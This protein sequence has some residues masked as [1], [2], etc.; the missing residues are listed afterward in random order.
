MDLVP[1]AS[2][3][4]CAVSSTT[5][6]F[7]PAIDPEGWVVSEAALVSMAGRPLTFPN[8]T[9]KTKNVAELATLSD[10]GVGK[11]GL[12]P[13]RGVYLLGLTARR[14][15]K[16]LKTV[17]LKVLAE[18]IRGLQRQRH[19]N[20]ATVIP[21][22]AE[23]T[24]LREVTTALDKHWASGDQPVAR[25][26]RD[27]WSP[28][29]S[30]FSK[31][32]ESHEIDEVADR[33]AVIG[34]STQPIPG[35]DYGT[36][37]SSDPEVHTIFVPPP[38]LTPKGVNPAPRPFVALFAH[39]AIRSSN[40]LLLKQHITVASDPEVETVLRHCRAYPFATGSLASAVDLAT[41]QLQIATGRNLAS[42]LDASIAS[43]E[44]TDAS[45]LTLNLQKGVLTQP[46]LKPPNAFTP[47]AGAT[48]A[49]EMP[50]SQ[51]QLDL[52]PKLIKVLRTVH[53]RHGTKARRLLDWFDGRSPDEAIRIA[54]RGVPGL[55]PIGRIPSRHRRW[56][57]SQL[58]EKGRDLVQTML[59]CG[60]THGRCVAPLYYHSPT[61]ESLTALY[62]KSVWPLFNDDPTGLPPQ[63]TGERVGPA[64]LPKIALSRAGVRRL[65]HRLNESADAVV[66]AG[67]LRIA[68]FHNRFVDYL[69]HHICIITSHRPSKALYALTRN[70]FDLE[71][72]ICVLSDK[73]VDLAHVTRLCSM[74]PRLSA[75]IRGYM[76][77]LEALAGL[78]FSP[79]EL[80]R[81]IKKIL[82][83]KAPLLA[84]LEADLT[85]RLG[86]EIEWK[87]SRPKEW[88]SLPD[89]WYR[90]FVAAKLREMGVPADAVF[91]QLGHL[92][93]AGQ[94]FG[95]DSP[96]S[97]IL[98]M[99]SLREG[100]GKIEDVLGVRVLKGL[101]SA[102]YQEALPPLQTWDHLI[103]QHEDQERAARRSELEKL[104]AT[105]KESRVR[106]VEWLHHHLPEV[107]PSAEGALMWISRHRRG[108][109]SETPFWRAKISP[110]EVRSL[111]NLAK[112]EFSE[113]PSVQV[114]I[115]NQLCRWLRG[116][117][118]RLQVD[119]QD[120]G[121]ITP[122]PIA[123]LSPFLKDNC[124]ATQQMA[125]ARKYLAEQAKRGVVIPNPA[126]AAL[127]LILYGYVT[128][129]DLVLQ[130]LS[131]PA[132]K[133]SVPP[134]DGDLLIW[135]HDQGE[136][137]GFCDLASIALSLLEEPVV[138]LCI[139]GLSRAIALHLPESLVGSAPEMT[140][141]RLCE[142]A[143]VAARIEYSSVARAAI[144]D[145]TDATPSHQAAFF[146]R[147]LPQSGR[148]VVGQGTDQIDLADGDSGAVDDPDP[149]ERAEVGCWKHW[150]PLR[151]TVSDPKGVIARQASPRSRTNSKGLTHSRL[152]IRRALDIAFPEPNDPKG[153]KLSIIQ[154]L[155][156]FARDMAING[157]TQKADPA[158]STI[159]TY[160]SVIGPSLVQCFAGVDLRDL[161]PDDFEDG[162][163]LVL[164]A[165]STARSRQRA[166]LQAKH[167]HAVIQRV[168]AIGSIEWAWLNEYDLESE[169]R[170]KPELIS[171]AEYQLA[172]DWLRQQLDASALHAADH[173]G[174]RRHCFAT[175]IILML[176][177]RTGARI[178]EIVR[179]RHDDLL[180]FGDHIALIIR[181]SRFR[182]LKTKAAR[183]LVDLTTRLTAD[184][185]TLLRQW[186]NVMEGCRAPNKGGMHPLFGT[187]DDGSQF[188]ATDTVRKTIQA[189]FQAGAGREMWPH[190]LRHAWVS[191]EYPKAAGVDLEALNI[192]GVR[193]FHNVMTE[194]G[195]ARAKTG[196]GSYLHTGWRFRSQSIDALVEDESMRWILRWVSGLSVDHVDKIWHRAKSNISDGPRP[197][198]WI[199]AVAIK[200]APV[201]I[202]VREKAVTDSSLSVVPRGGHLT[203]VQLD[204]LLELA[205]DE[206]E[207]RRLAPGFGISAARVEYLIGACQWLAQDAS[208]RLLSSK[209]RRN[210]SGREPLPRLIG[211]DFVGQ[212]SVKEW[213]RHAGEMSQLFVRCYSP[214]EARK[215]RLVGAAH[216][217]A[218]LHGLMIDVG[219]P[220]SLLNLEGAGPQGVLK[221]GQG[222]KISGFHRMTRLLALISIW[223]RIW[224]RI[225][226]KSATDSD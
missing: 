186:V 87:R 68:E 12:D 215:D 118:E 32:L 101:A 109:G 59:L 62:K 85:P 203:L 172:I 156:T 157:T 77:H 201:R 44:S 60:D 47:A 205:G 105:M 8:F 14:S 70:A 152:D 1:W 183:R 36:C 75:Q 197:D 5:P 115:H 182:A 208:Y 130:L 99:R 112:D 136:P 114:A 173:T 95:P 17:H 84:Y 104:R 211:F 127:A 163:R 168:H 30:N 165:A 22:I 188:V 111:N 98:L 15:S 27:G 43:E 147:Q 73:R 141:A 106:A 42:L 7:L 49:F 226:T 169:S 192:D 212:V 159:S 21:Q 221:V 204:R 64:H 185:R 6:W 28:W 26:W 131:K 170:V 117:V 2:K 175:L 128:D 116:A 80:V 74:T 181:P 58:Q 140:L 37:S 178:S 9:G 148:L 154:A 209:T 164:E 155:A 16:V 102:D 149:R 107:A 113:D 35:D 63:D 167:F 97:P 195:H 162:Y 139:E 194:A 137:Q 190:L 19:S 67:P 218:R 161:D 123:E 135:Q 126:R 150:G 71:R 122:R 193:S 4:L 153:C 143:Q 24:N 10:G 41:L 171:E 13:L 55:T 52:P 177:R 40:S 198:R 133:G 225:P 23:L 219:V 3:R 196:I 180:D 108:S 206:A 184:E 207:V 210:T 90:S 92:E 202:A 39:Q 176:L 216:D 145:S 33:P 54:L 144:A 151:R 81:H 31:Q 79:D 69:T 125:A 129:P 121:L 120:I 132:T 224:V 103:R 110:D 179:L 18:H 200:A 83:G 100:L 214:Y 66:E 223:P 174:W 51:L 11:V 158:G 142:T 86:T 160:F 94:P 166:A 48:H 217:I 134:H 189:A 96:L 45:K 76:G 57:A 89:N 187:L 72:H 124:L 220:G 91:C 82:S 50:C 61:P 29:L 146:A 191:E 46:L 38:E 93:S 78:S 119:A 25:A 213:H 34:L 199:N 88:V 65:A 20:P 138:G 222:G 53:S 56:L